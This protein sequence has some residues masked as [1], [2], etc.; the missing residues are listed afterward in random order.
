MKK[1]FA[2]LLLLLLTSGCSVLM[3][4]VKTETHF[5]G[6]DRSMPTASFLA[7]ASS[8]VNAAIASVLPD[9][10]WSGYASGSAWQYGETYPDGRYRFHTGVAVDD[11]RIWTPPQ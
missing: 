7:K 11:V 1:L 9:G 3:P 5:Y 10:T 2:T 6:Y 4:S 8:E